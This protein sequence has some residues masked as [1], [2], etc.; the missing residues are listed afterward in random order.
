M[1]NQLNKIFAVVI[2]ILFFSLFKSYAIEDV[3]DLT[4]AIT[5]AREKFDNAS[6]AVTDQSKIIDEAIK[7]IDK[8]TEYVQ[9][10]I[11][12]DN[13]ED[14]IKTLNFIEKS[15][16]DVGNIIP[17]EFSSDMTN[18]D[19]SGISKEDMNLINELTAQMNVAKVEKENEFMSE[20]MDLNLKGIDTGLIQEN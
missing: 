18:I 4:N 8:A 17:Q 19:V 12:N 7:E 5:E 9:D 14:A 13:A 16:V 10:A 3:S 20:L 6:E 15:L 1:K 11:I 2:L